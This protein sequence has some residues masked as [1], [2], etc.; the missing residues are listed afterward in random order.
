MTQPVVAFVMPGAMTKD[1]F[2]T[3]DLDRLA[4]HAELRIDYPERVDDA[5]AARLVEGADVMVTCWGTCPLTDAILSKA[6]ALRLLSH[7]AGS[8]RGLIGGVADF[9]ARGIRV[10]TTSAAIAVGVAETC[11]GLMIC[12]VRRVFDHAADS[13]QGH[14]RTPETSAV[15][16]ELN[17][18]T[19]GVLAAS[20]VG[21]HFIGLCQS[22]EMTVLV[23]DPYITADQARE[24]GATKVEL[25]ELLRTSDVV[26][27]CVPNL[28]ST[29]KMINATGLQSMKDD[30]VLINTS[31]GPV[32]DEAALI[33]ELQKGRLFACL[34]VT[35]PE[36][37]APD[38]PLRTLPNCILTPHIA[39]AVTN[40]KLRQG[41][42]AAD[43]IIRFLTGEPLQYEV[44]EELFHRMA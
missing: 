22:L 43:E 11:L 20:R 44:T 29:Q 23:Y 13:R 34:D 41:R 12:G 31:R 15:T 4:D 39:G 18:L 36:P 38:N 3:E 8:I 32:I 14:W 7:S 16:R 26:N 9:W 25:D 42:M 40:G 2:R 19:V 10:T 1:C 28:P 35:D 6:P 30:A 17:F 24:L 21:R 5:C 27:C 33:A 37:P